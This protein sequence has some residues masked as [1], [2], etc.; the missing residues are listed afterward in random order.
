M[1]FFVTHLYTCDQY[2]CYKKCS[3]ETDDSTTGLYIGMSDQAL[4]TVN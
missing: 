2:N 1:M 3:V 4:Y